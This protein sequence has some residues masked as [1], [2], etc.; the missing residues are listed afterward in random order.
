[1]MKV[2]MITIKFVKKMVMELIPSKEVSSIKA[3]EPEKN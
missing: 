3:I 2:E 1:M